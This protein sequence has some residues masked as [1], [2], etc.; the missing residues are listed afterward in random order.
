[1]RR[2]VEMA[3]DVEAMVDRDDHDVVAQREADAVVARRVG[4]AVGERAAM[5]PDHDGPLG[6]VEPGRPD[7]QRQAVLADRQRVD[8]PPDRRQ[9]RPLRG[10]GGLRRAAGVGGR[11]AHAR[12]GLA[13]C[14]A[15]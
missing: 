4:R 9:L 10:S 2:Q 11:L 14:A 1:M 15:A 6:A 3:E 8:R 13:A 7:V 5:Q 12:P